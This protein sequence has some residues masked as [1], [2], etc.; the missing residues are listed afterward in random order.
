VPLSVKNRLRDLPQTELVSEADPDFEK[1]ASPAQLEAAKR[2]A[3]A[4]GVVEVSPDWERT[5]TPEQRKARQ[6]ETLRRETKP[7]ENEFVRMD[8]IVIAKYK[9]ELTFVHNRRLNSENACGIQVWESGKRFHGG[10]DQLMYCCVDTSEKDPSK[11]QGCRNFISSEDIDNGIAYC[12]HCQ[13]GVVS[14]KLGQIYYMNATPQKIAEKLVTVFRQLGSNADIY[15][16]FHKTD[17]RY[18]AMLRAKGPDVARKLKGMN[19][20]PL[21]NILKDTAS[22]ADLAGRFKAFL[23]A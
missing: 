15:I 14:N 12:R 18:V 6:R 17:I 21:K 16:K 13:R 19:I 20:Y 2:S 4:A 10:G 9:I 1:K 7:D 8:G 22:G 11:A 3:A 5:A 23:T